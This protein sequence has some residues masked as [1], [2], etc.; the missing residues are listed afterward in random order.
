MWRI[1]SGTRKCNYFSD[2]ATIELVIAL[3]SYKTWETPTCDSLPNLTHYLTHPP[4][5]KYV[6]VLRKPQLAHTRVPPSKSAHKAC[7]FV[8]YNFPVM[9]FMSKTT[10]FL[11]DTPAHL[12][13]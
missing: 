12:V 1:E 3:L 6:Y 13:G 5:T 7:Y 4:L 8:P 2:W 11:W 10:Q 9:T